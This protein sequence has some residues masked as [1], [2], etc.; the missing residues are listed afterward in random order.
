MKEKISVIFLLIS[1]FA[2][3]SKDDFIKT[4]S[5]MEYKLVQRDAGGIPV[6]HGQYLKLS[7]VQ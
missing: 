6:G 1:F 3:K 4:A 5:G 2:C 7:V